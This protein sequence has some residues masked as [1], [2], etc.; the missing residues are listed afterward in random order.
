[1]AAADD[2]ALVDSLADVWT[3]IDAFAVTLTDEEWK[4]PTELPGWTVQDTLA[5]IVGIESDLLGKPAPTAVDRDW[6]H[7]K[8]DI[9][10]ANER[11]VD[12]YRNRSGATVL[13]DFRDVTAARL[14]VL[15]DPACDFGAAAWTPVG[16]GTVRD[17]LPFRIF[18]SWVHEQDMRRAVGREGGWDTAAAGLAVDRMVAIMPMIVGKKVGPPDATVVGFAISGP[19]ERDVA[20]VVQDGRAAFASAGADPTVTLRLDV[21]TFVRLAAGR[22]D[23]ADVVELVTF[24]GD[25]ALGAAVVREMNFLF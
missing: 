6:P 11:W 17:L 20:I 9:G 4:T 1:V 10:L 12:A 25:E 19:V 14:V 3:S 18:D 22:G 21:E 15:R 13:G 24:D 8:N 23:P 7:V 16:P 2:A 5:H